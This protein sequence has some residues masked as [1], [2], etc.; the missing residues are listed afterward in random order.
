MKEQAPRH[1]LP[2]PLTALVGREQET[3]SLQQ[4]LRQ[5]DVRLVTLMGPAGVGKTRLALQVASR[6]V[7]DYAAGVYLVRLSP[8]HTVEQTLLTVAQTVGAWQASHQPPTDLLLAYLHDKPMLLLLDN[9]EQV[10]AAAPVFVRLLEECAQLKIFVTSR[11]ALHVRGEIRF[12]VPP[13][14]VP[15]LG[16][17]PDPVDLARFESVALFLQRVRA[18][19]PSFQL[20]P[21]NAQ[22]VAEI[23]VRLEGLPLAL[24]LAAARSR[25]LSLQAL[26][27]RLTHRLSTLID[28][29]R[30]MPPHQQTLRSTLNWSYDLLNQAEQCLFWRLGVF[31]DSFTLQAAEAV[32][33]GAWGPIL[34]HPAGALSATEGINALLDHSLLYRA[35][36]TN[37]DDD[38]TR[39]YL[40]ETIREYALERLAASGEE[41]AIRRRHAGYFVALAEEAEPHLQ[42]TARRGWIRRLAADYDNL[43]E[44]LQWSLTHPATT[45]DIYLRLCGALAWFWRHQ[46]SLSEGLGWLESALQTATQPAEAQQVSPARAR[47]LFGAGMLQYHQF[48]TAA[49]YAYLTESVAMWRELA[50]LQQLSYALVYLGLA[51]R[52]QGALDIARAVGAESVALFRAG[53]DRW[54]LALALCSLGIVLLKIDFPAAQQATQ[55]SVAIF[56][57]LGDAWGQSLALGRLGVVYHVQGDDQTAQSLLEKSVLISRENNDKHNL[58][59]RLGIL[60]DVLRSQRRYTQAAALY[61]E[62]LALWR[63]MGFKRGMAAALH[64]LGYV[65]RFLGEYSRARALFGECLAI[66]QQTE[67]Q[68]TIGASLAGLSAVASA[69][70][71]LTLGAQL[72]GAAEATFGRLGFHLDVVDRTE[73]IG[74]TANLRTR[75]GEQAFATAWA[76]GQAMTPAQAVATAQHY[77][78]APIADSSLPLPSG[79]A[80]RQYFGLTEREAE[81][82]CLVAEGLSNADIA[83][84]LSLSI[85]TVKV[86]LRAIFS[87]LDIKSRSAAARFALDHKLC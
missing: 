77:L 47:A 20:T 83:Q 35:E 81:V 15:D 37:A 44:A 53:G 3:Y 64:N 25:L 61:D 32:A 58:A 9:F 38:E 21:V 8:L 70:G 72:A 49:A 69:S 80:S 24:E 86:H 43:R 4:L 23:C 55:E 40:L 29:A 76:D 63:E 68:P 73:Y 45:T 50:D 30:D 13:L 82:L 34:S 48:S 65:A 5:P 12:P 60:G 75:L 6:L 85:H 33:G 87:K 26:R 54:G 36:T 1:N 17:L 62:S 66:G 7:S 28:G 46:G 11:I 42:G 22:L 78:A 57:E 31:A 39:F 56:H 84:R 27:G 67:H 52:S 59:D 10:V 79:S 2:A 19:N 74:A 41:V 71:H 14:C 18:V 51:G 16:H